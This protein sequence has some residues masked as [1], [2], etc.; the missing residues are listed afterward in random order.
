MDDLDNSLEWALETTKKVTTVYDQLKWMWEPRET[1]VETPRVGLAEGVDV[2]NTNIEVNRRADVI[3]LGKQFYAQVK[4]LFGLGYPSTEKQPVPIV[5]QGT[6]DATMP[7]MS[8][9]MGIGTIAIIAAGAYFL[10][11]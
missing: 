10:L 1:I 4:G 8:A 5:E 2:K 6:V 3:E 9:G 7:G 11:K